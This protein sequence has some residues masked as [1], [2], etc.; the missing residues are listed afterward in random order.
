MS[1]I[2]DRTWYN[3]RFIII[4]FIAYVDYMFSIVGVVLCLYSCS[5]SAHSDHQGVGA[6][7]C[8]SVALRQYLSTSAPYV[9]GHVVDR[10]G[11]YYSFIES[12]VVHSLNIGLVRL[13][14]GVISCSVL[15]P[16]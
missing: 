12:C 13:S 10:K 14:C 9:S 15:D 6:R 8:V 7:S 16:P 2:L 4:I 11:D 1:Q 5:Y 3:S